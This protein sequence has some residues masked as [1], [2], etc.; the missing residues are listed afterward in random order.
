MR[1][2]RN[3]AAVTGAWSFSGRHIAGRLLANG[4][5]VRSISNRSPDPRADPYNGRVRRI[6]YTHDTG[7]LA[8]ALT[9][10][11]VL[12]SNFWT[13]HDRPPV[14]H[15]GPWLSHLQAVDQSAVLIEAARQAGFERLVWTS[16][17]NPGR[18][19]DPSYFTG[20]AVAEQL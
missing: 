15:R 20:K 19:P 9:G 5:G 14:G 6:R 17:T 12:V 8:A 4:W 2:D 16:I 1:S 3:V 7:R 11:Q 10:C 18:D 13:R